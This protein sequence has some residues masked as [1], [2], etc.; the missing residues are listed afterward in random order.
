MPEWFFPSPA[1]PPPPPG[2]GGGTPGDAEDRRLI[3]L[4]QS[5]GLESPD[6]RRTCG[7]LLTRA[8]GRLFAVCFRMLGSRQEA[9]ELTQE[10]MV[11]I[12]KG[13]DTYDGRR[14]GGVNTWM[15]RIA[16]NACLSY[17][18]KQK[19]R[20]HASLDSMG[21]RF[22]VSGGR[23]G[24]G[25]SRGLGGGGPGPRLASAGGGSHREETAGGTGGMAGGGRELG[26]SERV[27][28]HERS[29]L[30]SAALGRVGPEHRAV[31]VLRDIQG[32]EYEQIADVLE[33][34]IGTVKSRL[35][36]A[37]AALRGVIEQMEQGGSE[38]NPGSG[39]KKK[40]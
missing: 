3:A 17:L 8:Q 10:A 34:N 21:S 27:E 14:G 38:P 11:K 32:L 12:L 9:E 5:R 2:I 13:L 29:V 36:R 16:M 37:R 7:E 20:K 40:P 39:G 25:G 26:P 28:L 35:F 6:G 22:P 1:D 30:V 31:L 4:A 23:P 15:T 24:S 19:L 18:R 33:M